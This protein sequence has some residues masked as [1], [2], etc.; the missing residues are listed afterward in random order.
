MARQNPKTIRK[1]REAKAKGSKK[2]T[3]KVKRTNTLKKVKKIAEAGVPANPAGLDVNITNQSG[4]QKSNKENKTISKNDVSNIKPSEN[5]HNPIITEWGQ[6][7]KM[8]NDVSTIDGTLYKDEI[9]KVESVGI[10]SD[11]KV[12]DNL[13]RFWY[14]GLS[15]IS[16]KI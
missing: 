15:D 12:I 14:V 16:T 6:K 7:V 10:I 5:T 1:N 2:I 4:V 8:L 11:L 9:V 3:T 13:G